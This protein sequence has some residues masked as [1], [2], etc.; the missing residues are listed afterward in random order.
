MEKKIQL[1]PKKIENKE[2]KIDFK[3]YNADEVDLFLDIV[4]EDYERFAALLSKAFEEIDTH[5]KTVGEL[6][7]KI[8]MLER[9]KA[10]QAQSIATMEENANTNVDILKRLSLLEK[11]V[12]SGEK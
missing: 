9:E 6:N 11:A 2:F 8:A 7:E 12:F 4:C 5:K 3:G 10:I 1:T